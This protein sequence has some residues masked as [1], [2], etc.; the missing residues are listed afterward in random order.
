MFDRYG[1]MIGMVWGKGFER[2]DTVLRIISDNNFDGL[3][4][5]SGPR[6]FKLQFDFCQDIQSFKQIRWNITASAPPKCRVMNL[7]F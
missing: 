5:V 3:K 7:P 1:C 4:V 2:K 6:M